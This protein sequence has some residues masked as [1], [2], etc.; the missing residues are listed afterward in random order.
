MYAVAFQIQE[1]RGPLGPGFSGP[2]LLCARLG[3]REEYSQL[4]SRQLKQWAFPLLLVKRMTFVVAKVRRTPRCADKRQCVKQSRCYNI[5]LYGHLFEQ[6]RMNHITFV[7][8]KVL[9]LIC[10]VCGVWTMIDSPEHN[11]DRNSVLVGKWMGLAY[12]Q[13]F[14]TV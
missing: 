9:G 6:D 11:P 8:L 14:G 3:G 1:S 10:F 5:D 2:L 12:E 7:Q 13:L 4:D